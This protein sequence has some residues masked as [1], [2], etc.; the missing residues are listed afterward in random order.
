[1][2]QNIF[3][4]TGSIASKITIVLFAVTGAAATGEYLKANY[5]TNYQI[6]YVGVVLFWFLLGGI[7]E[8]NKL[9]DQIRKQKEQRV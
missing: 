7:Y 2:T 6:S 8:Y 9:R 3:L 1:M 4:I 5:S